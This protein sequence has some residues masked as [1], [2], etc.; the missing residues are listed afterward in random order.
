MY[1]IWRVGGTYTDNH[2]I[3]NH[4]KCCSKRFRV[5][6]PERVSNIRRRVFGPKT[7]WLGPSGFCLRQSRNSCK[8]FTVVDGN[9][10][11]RCTA[12]THRT[13]QSL[14]IVYHTAFFFFAEKV[15]RIYIRVRLRFVVSATFFSAPRAFPR[16]AYIPKG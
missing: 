2:I 15:L 9:T 16:D 5:F 7:L 8:R 10:H 12:R 4:S 14:R 1:N 13:G 6:V 11:G 3:F